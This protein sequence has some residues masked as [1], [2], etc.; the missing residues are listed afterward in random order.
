MRR[1][2]L[3]AT[4]ATTY[5]VAA[6]MVAPGSG[7]RY[8]P[9]IEIPTAGFGSRLDGR[10][11]GKIVAHQLR[12]RTGPTGK[13]V[14]C[15][16]AV[17]RHQHRCQ[18]L[19]RFRVTRHVGAGPGQMFEEELVVSA[20]RQAD[21]LATFNGRRLARQL[22]RVL[23]F[24]DHRAAFQPGANVVAATLLEG[25][26]QLLG[27]LQ[28]EDPGVLGLRRLAFDEAALHQDVRQRCRRLRLEPHLRNLRCSRPVD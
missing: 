4:A 9:E 19:A 22:G 18:T 20:G 2:A 12:M 1:A 24:L 15:T 11:P 8:S 13:Q 10:P 17:S 5:V 6:W 14:V 27:R 21:R 23:A 25:G 7:W 26:K 16:A 28:L 3:L